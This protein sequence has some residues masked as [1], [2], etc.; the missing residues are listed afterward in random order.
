MQ[1]SDWN[2]VFKGNL[3]A[4][5]RHTAKGYER[6]VRPP[7]VRL[8]LKNQTGEILLTEEF[9]SELN[10]K[11]FRLPGGKVFDDLDSYLK[12]RTDETK[13][14]D[15]VLHAAKLEAKQE[16]G[17]DAITDLKVV[18]K[19]VAGASVEWDL[20]YLSGII[21]AQSEQ[22]LEDEEKERGISVHFF[23]QETVKK[24]ILDGSISEERTQ[25]VLTRLFNA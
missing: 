21:T 2:V 11:D 19:A 20:Y 18:A 1:N 17:V 6:A 10:R 4:V 25:A 14:S 3:I 9:R 7:G 15:A 23:P 8:I 13:L 24:M 16:T 22:E 5:E 12:V